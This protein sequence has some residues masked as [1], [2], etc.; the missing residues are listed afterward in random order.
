MR[1]WVGGN[2]GEPLIGML[3]KI[4]PADQVV[5]ELSSFQLEYFAS[6]PRASPP[7]GWETL[8]QGHSPHIA[9]ILNITPNHLDRHPSM[10]AYVE[11][12]SH[13][14]RYQSSADVCV[15]GAGVERYVANVPCRTLQFSLRTSVEEGAFLSG[16]QLLLRLA[17]EEED[18]CGADE[19]PTYQ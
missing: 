18:V 6:Q 11:A 5:T 15:L 16:G 2:I 8:A 12:K 10:E 4:D 17:G 19:M 1:T 7:M 14:C 13:I 9:A 3:E